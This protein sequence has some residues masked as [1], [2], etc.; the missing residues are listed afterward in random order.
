MVHLIKEVVPKSWSKTGVLH[1]TDPSK[2]HPSADWLERLWVYL[3]R[4]HPDDLSPY[5]GVPLLPLGDD[6]VVPLSLP[7]QVILRSEY[8]VTLNPGLS[9]CLELVGVTVVDGLTEYV[10]CHAAVVGSFVRPPLPENVVDAMFTASAKTDVVAAFRDHT[11]EEEKLELLA[12]IG[13]IHCGNIEERHKEFLRT[14]PLFK[15]TRSTTDQPQFVS[16]AEVTKAYACH[17]V[18]TLGEAFI[19]GSSGQALTAAKTLGVD[20]LN[21]VSFIKDHVLPE[22]RNRRL[23]SED[24]QRCLHYVFDDIQRLQQDDPNILM[25]LSD[26]QFVTTVTGLVVSPSSVYDPTD[27]TLQT[28]FVDEDDHFPGGFYSS[29]EN[30]IILRKMGMKNAG[31]VSACDILNTANQI[32]KMNSTLADDTTQKAEALLSFLTNRCDLLRDEMAVKGLVDCLKD[33]AW[34]PVCTDM[35]EQF[36]ADLKVDA[37][38]VV[39]TAAD[40]K[41]YDW[42]S[43]VGSVVPIV[44]CRANETIAQLFGWNRTPCL[45]DVVRQFTKLVATYSCDAM[46]DYTFMV[47]NVYAVLSE[48]SVDDVQETLEAIGLRDWVWNGE[49]FTAVE[50]AL[51]QPPPLPLAPYVYP[52]PQALQQFHPRLSA[53]GVTRQCSN[54]VLVNVLL[55]MKAKYDSGEREHGTRALNEGNDTT[56]RTPETD[57]QVQRNDTKRHSDQE[58]ESDLRLANDILNHIKLSSHVPDRVLVPTDVEG[59]VCLLPA[60]ECTYCDVEWLRK[61]FDSVEFDES[62][63]IILVHHH[64]PTSTAAALGVPTLMSRMLHAEELEITSFG[65]GEPLTSTL[66]RMLEDYT[67]GLAIPKELVQNA[68]DAGATEVRFLYDERTHNDAKKYL[69]DEG[70]RE[71][72]GPALW[73]YSNS[74]FTDSDLDNIIRLGSAAKK[75]DAT[76]IG[77][78]GLGFNVVYNLTDV[79]SFVTGN[80]VVFFDPHTTHLGHSIHDKSKPGIKIDLR[81]NKTLLRKLSHQFQPYKGVFGC[82][83]DAV[84][85]PSWP[86]TLFRFPLRT[87]LQAQRSDISGLHYDTA[88]VSQLLTLLADNAHSL[89]LFTQNVKKVS[90]WHLTSDASPENAVNIF[91]V[92]RDTVTTIR[93]VSPYAYADAL[94]GVECSGTFLKAAVRYMNE[95][96]ETAPTRAPQSSNIIRVDATLCDTTALLQTRPAASVKFWLRCFCVAEGRALTLAREMTKDGFV[97]AAA[98]AIRLLPIE[99]GYVPATPGEDGRDA[100]QVFNFLPLP[101]RSGLPVHINGMFAVH[102]NRRR[103][104]ERTAD[105]TGS[106]VHA[107]NDALL[108]DGVV[109]AYM[110]MLQDLQS[111]VATVEQDVP[112]YRTWPTVADTES[113]IQ[114][115]VNVFYRILA[116][117]AA[118]AP[119]IYNVDDASVATL[120]KVLFLDPELTTSPQLQRLIMSVFRQCVAGRTPVSV[121]SDVLDSFRKAG[122]CHFIDTI[123]YDMTR[124]FTEIFFPNLQ[125]LSAVERDPLV[126]LALESKKVDSLLAE[127]PC[128]PTSPD[129]EKLRTPQDLVHPRG[130]VAK[131]YL[132][133]DSRFPY[134][135]NFTDD[136]CLH[137][138]HKRGMACNEITWDNLIERLG[139]V[140]SV[141]NNDRAVAQN[142]TDC[143]LEFLSLKLIRQKGGQTTNE[144]EAELETKT[145]AAREAI[146][147]IPFVPLL[148]R[149]RHFPVTW[150]NEEYGASKVLPPSVLYPHEQYRLVSAVFPIADDKNMKTEVRDIL[151]LLQKKP[152]LDDVMRQ[153]DGML[154]TELSSLGNDEYNAFH[155]ACLSV[156]DFLQRQTKVTCVSEVEISDEARRLQSVLK[157]RPC[158]LVQRHFHLPR[159]VT[160]HGSPHCEPYLYWLPAELARRY[161]PL[162]ELLGVRDNFATVDYVDAIRELKETEGD[163]RLS[164][165]TLQLAVTLATCLHS[166][167]EQGHQ[168][169]CDVQDEH[170]SIYL[171]NE[172]GVLHP[173]NDLCYND[174]PRRGSDVTTNSLRQMDE[175]LAVGGYTHPALSQM[176]AVGLGVRTIDREVLT[177]SARSRI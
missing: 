10:R 40:V 161:T 124:F 58:I 72:Q 74:M 39:R 23:A 84:S 47:K 48:Q 17:C 176:V 147:Q 42:A 166:S 133:E 31:D 109:T 144:N 46:T 3:R 153:F 91:S 83:L 88:H 107:W 28:L 123:V 106:D 15:T 1:A 158:I 38:A 157:S 66:R 24:V 81:R 69:F 128:V 32:A 139:S 95:W 159:K 94:P 14:L 59:T 111:L 4:Q 33:I 26:I 136:S 127:Y 75:M 60:S 27:G 165:R 172:R 43:I 29:P 143:A 52:L 137:R 116:A 118:T 105:D 148:P 65:Q 115:V 129:G 100:G 9:H 93:D 37:G 8:G 113:D 64:L 138:L 126:R 61:G 13:T 21:D 34:V 78:F 114:P 63:G 125:R 7:S 112:F 119:V 134:G 163:V 36:P 155:S 103:L 110:Q 79:P 82:D 2:Q 169:L 90:L 22:I 67:D 175:T 145:E 131:L 99:R 70:M 49:G 167:V 130:A 55:D 117:R 102:S 92:C 89:L 30:L 150:K 71:C 152:S 80:V 160:F 140:E 73:C 16:A 174:N 68:D 12:L 35:P 151:G 120:D 132:P 149:P 171:P 77:R 141:N 97:P 50:R 168:Q 19:D 122:C 20:I 54:D 121:D 108:E 177:S 162:M 44:R 170:G 57:D 104:V 51:L 25:H 56:Q 87:K 6:E 53:C 98:V 96:S 11:T 86:G 45:E 142:R 18:V 156:Y 135:D 85:G 101:V 5:L 154:D 62:D 173:I 41:S 76:K 164:G 146:I